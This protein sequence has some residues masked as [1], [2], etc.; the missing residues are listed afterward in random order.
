M[1]VEIH[2]WRI[3][4]ITPLM[5]NNPAATMLPDTGGMTAA[6]KTYDDSE[7][8]AIRLYK[9]AKEENIFL[10]D[11]FRAGILTAAAG[12]KINKKAAK[13][14]LA[15]SVFPVEPDFL[16]LDDKGK[17]AKE[18]EIDKRRV[19]IGKSGV[20]RCRPR[21]SPWQANLPL[22]IDR[23]FITNL[24]L[25][26]EILNIAG[27]IVGLGEMRPDTSKGKSGVGSFGRY[28]ATLVK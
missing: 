10:T 2:V 4:G 11:G 7:E 21:F 26:T 23:D 24:D 25:V 27:R 13:Q 8:A 6:K 19:V 1:G 14:T 12:R 28:R 20:L 9:N 18:Y 22:E 15:G 5:L 17:P 3:V 16:I